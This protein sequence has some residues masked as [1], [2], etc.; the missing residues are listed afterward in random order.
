MAYVELKKVRDNSG[1]ISTSIDSASYLLNWVYRTVD[2][3]KD[4]YVMP[5]PSFEKDTRFIKDPTSKSAMSEFIADARILYG[6]HNVSVREIET[7]PPDSVITY[8][9]LLAVPEFKP[10]ATS[11]IDSSLVT[12]IDPFY[13]LEVLIQ[14]SMDP[15]F[16]IGPFTNPLKADEVC[17]QFIRNGRQALLVKYVNGEAKLETED[18]IR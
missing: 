13:G 5:V 12:M 16:I 10:T 11:S 6:K 9:V 8:K 14:D 2:D 1:S 17:Q 4:Y 18:A 15:T 3:N 7:K